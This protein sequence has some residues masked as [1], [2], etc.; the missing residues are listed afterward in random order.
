MPPTWTTSSSWPSPPGRCSTSRRRTRCSTRATRCPTRS[1]SSSGWTSRPRR[2]IAVQ[3]GEEA[4]RLQHARRAEGRGRDPVAQRPGDRAARVQVGRASHL[5]I[6]RGVF[7][8]G[9]S[10]YGYLNALKADLFLSANQE[11]VR[12]GAGRGLPGGA[13]LPAVDRG[14]P[15]SHPEEVRIAFDGD[16]VMFSDQ[17]EQ[18][19][20]ELGLPAFEA[21]EKSTRRRTAAAR[22]R[23]NRSCVRC[24]GCRRTRRKT[25][26]CASARRWSPRAARRPTTARSAR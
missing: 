13:G 15:E 7:L 25:S 6:T 22:A 5:P 14:Q 12:H 16:A 3:A 1:C 17:A 8:R 10:P 2:A 24:T 26:A 9:R 23:C 11:D 21:H 20:Q 4:A 19:Y 18:V